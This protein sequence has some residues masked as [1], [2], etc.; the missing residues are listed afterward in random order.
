PEEQ[1]RRLER[2]LSEK[3]GRIRLEEVARD[4]P[5]NVISR[6][7]VELIE[8]TIHEDGGH[9]A[10][11]ELLSGKVP[12]YVFSNEP[13]DQK[14]HAGVCLLR[15]FLDRPVQ[16]VLE[17]YRSRHILGHPSILLEWPLFI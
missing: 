17:P 10:Q 7:V 11:S 14:V 3:I 15:L 1:N 2:E 16:C 5:A 4:A 8:E 13:V 12:I 6:F 9:R